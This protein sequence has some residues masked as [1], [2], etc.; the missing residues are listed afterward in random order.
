MV[1]TN[2]CVV[3]IDYSTSSPCICISA[4]N[5]YDFHYL[6]KVKKH[7]GEKEFDYGIIEG[8]YLPKQFDSKI[9]QYSFIANWAIDVLDRYTPEV[10]WLEDYAF[11]ATGKVFHIGENTG[12]LKYRLM[13]KEIPYRVVAP[14][15]V[16]SS[17]IG[18]G[19]ASKDDVIQN[20][21]RVFQTNIYDVVDTSTLNPVS[22]I[23]DSYHICIYGIQQ[24]ITEHFN[25]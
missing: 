14:T 1:S 13:K 16:K 4:G 9:E 21:N 2:S 17:T 24:L 8:T 19:N 3:G 15:T 10:V 18:K 7:V 25:I 6:T 12:I 5:D 20:F 23:A 22:D 11:A